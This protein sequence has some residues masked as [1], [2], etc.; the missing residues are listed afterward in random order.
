M[1]QTIGIGYGVEGVGTVVTENDKV[2]ASFD[3]VIH[4]IEG[5]ASKMTGFASGFER[6]SKG[7]STMGGTKFSE[8]F[9][10]STSLKTA[11]TNTGLL[12]TALE[13][14]PGRA[15]AAAEA[16]GKLSAAVGA[17][18]AQMSL[19][20]RQSKVPIAPN[21]VAPA[22]SKGGGAA[23]G[24]M[25]PGLGRV[26]GYMLG[27]R[28]ASEGLRAAHYAISDIILGKSRAGLSKGLGELS[29][30]GMDSGQKA[31]M[32]FSAK[33]FSQKFWTVSA[34]KYVEALSYTASGFDINA[35]GSSNLLKLHEASMKMSMVAKMSAD[36][37]AAMMT[38]SVLAIISQL[39]SEIAD[40]LR[41][42]LSA[43]VPHFGK[44]T[45]GE[46]G[47]KLTAQYLKAM[48][49][50]MMWGPDIQ[51]AFKYALPNFL[52]MGWSPAGALAFTG[53][54]VN[55][56][57]HAGQSGRG[58]KDIF[59]KEEETFAKIFVK[60]GGYW[61]EEGA[62]DRNTGR[63]LTGIERKINKENNRRYLE[64]GRALVHKYLQ[65]PETAAE[66]LSAAG[67]YYR[68]L[69]DPA[70]GGK[71]TSK[72][73]GVST[74]FQPL[75][76]MY[77]K[78]SFE[79][80]MVKAKERIEHASYKDTDE[81]V[82][83]SI[84]DVGSSYARIMNAFDNLSTSLADYP[85]AHW[86]ASG[87]TKQLD[88]TRTLIDLQKKAIA[89]H[90]DNAQ[91]NK[92]ID[93][94]DQDLMET[95]GQKRLDIL[96]YETQRAAKDKNVRWFWPTV[97]S[98]MQTAIGYGLPWNWG[99]ESE[100]QN[101]MSPLKALWQGLT[102]QGAGGLNS[103]G[104]TNNFLQGVDEIVG[105]IGKS[106]GSLPESFDQG[107][108]YIRAS[109]SDFYESATQPFKDA[110]AYIDSSWQG[111]QDAVMAPFRKFQELGDWFTGGGKEVPAP[112]I[113]QTQERLPGP[114]QQP[115]EPEFNP[116]RFGS[117]V[118]PQQSIHIT[119]TQEPLNVQSHLHLDGRILAMAVSDIIQQN[120]DVNYQTYG[121]DPMGFYCV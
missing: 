86:I 107:R 41:Q 16:L 89:E 49:T 76:L 15:T 6:I 37:S 39:P 20:V 52:E 11:A 117:Y 24:S 22:G 120:R 55:A 112:P 50:T 28:L 19:A 61:G 103:W 4:K 113:P 66:L 87:V 85:G 35:I 51:N 70:Q 57:F 56:G 21:M 71:E 58:I 12:N 82:K 116:F 119:L 99:N 17:Y 81:I 1:D 29:A 75:F 45:I 88:Y 30:V 121:A 10:G 118:P 111:I 115:V 63:Q 7:M 104:T 78:K 23:T 96:R 72:S 36:K 59:V 68:K 31:Q 5:F 2:I 8:F 67:V 48:K 62:F 3:S 40:K 91:I 46:L 64:A 69:T 98:H 53:S 100:E 54:L 83:K 102:F 94:N 90:W 108:D 38:K 101:R 14:T 42:G 9:K 60:G 13:S 18:N 73:L 43:E 47:E 97:G 95:F 74:Q 106:I 65:T 33:Q 26:P 114:Y 44:V 27:W 110:T 92:W 32:E 80:E 105:G 34:E 109:I 93:E 79:D 25:F 84:E 77:T